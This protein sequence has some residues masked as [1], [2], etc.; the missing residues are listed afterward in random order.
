MWLQVLSILSRNMITDKVIRS[1]YSDTNLFNAFCGRESLF[2]MY[3]RAS[4]ATD[5]KPAESFS[6]Y[7]FSDMFMY[8]YVTKR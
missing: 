7:Y 6:Q 4:T 8:I 5:S 1:N 3:T 2:F